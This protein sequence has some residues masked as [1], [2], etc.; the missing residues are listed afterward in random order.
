MQRSRNATLRN[1]LPLRSAGP[2]AMAATYPPPSIQD[3]LIE[4]MW[5]RLADQ[6]HYAETLEHQIAQ[7]WETIRAQEDL[8]KAHLVN[9]RTMMES[10]DQLKQLHIVLVQ[11]LNELKAD[12]RGARHDERRDGEGQSYRHHHVYNS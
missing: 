9:E 12:A 8:L 11:Q 5:E 2:T 3:A 6:K 10:F 7:M 4:G 1:D